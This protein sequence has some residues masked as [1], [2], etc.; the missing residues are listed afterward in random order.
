MFYLAQALDG[1]LD[2]GPESLEARYYSEDEIPWEDLSFRTVASTLKQF[3]ADRRAGAFLTHH[4]TIDT[5]R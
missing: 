5:Y 2:P 1:E 3:F 4:S